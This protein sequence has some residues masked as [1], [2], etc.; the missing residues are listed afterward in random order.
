MQKYLVCWV[1]LALFACG[2]SSSVDT[3]DSTQP[4][5][6]ADND[7]SLTPVSD[8]DPVNNDSENDGED[9]APRPRDFRA[10]ARLNKQPSSC[11]VSVGSAFS[12]PARMGGGAL[13][14]AQPVLVPCMTSLR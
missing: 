4:G 12:G 5:R 6:Q 2:G 10:D 1:S 7:T 8:R 13:P 9:G 3:P 14:S 11:A